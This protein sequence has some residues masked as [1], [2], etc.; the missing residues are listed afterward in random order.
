DLRLGSDTTYEL[1]VQNLGNI[2]AVGVVLTD[3]LPAGVHFVSATSDVGSCGEAGGTVTCQLGTLPPQL[4]LEA[5][6]VHIVVGADPA[7]VGQV[8]TNEAQLSSSSPETDFRQNTSSTKGKVFAV[9]ECEGSRDCD[10]SVQSSPGGDD[11]SSS[12][13]GDD[14]GD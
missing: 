1:K 8:L 6:F 7:V 3:P 14:P 13:G 9:G 5:D 11:G 10:P 12:S 2:P 4:D